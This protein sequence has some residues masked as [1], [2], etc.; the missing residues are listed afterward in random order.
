LV[1]SVRF[2]VALS[3]KRWLP[4]LVVKKKLPSTRLR[5][6]YR[7]VGCGAYD[8]QLDHVKR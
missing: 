3:Q 4:G 8:G 7:K 5:Y 1:L 2:V 6:Q